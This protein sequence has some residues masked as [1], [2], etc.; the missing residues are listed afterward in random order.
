MFAATSSSTF[1]APRSTDS[2][3]R[4][5][6]TPSNAS[7]STSFGR[8]DVTSAGCG[9]ASTFSNSAQSATVRASGPSWQYRSRLNGASTG[10]RPCGGLN[11]TTPLIDA[12]IRIDPP[13][14]EPLAS[15]E[16]PLASDAPD[17]PL[18]PPTA[19]AGFHGLRVTP[20]SFECVYPA[21]DSSGVAVRA[22]TTAPAARIRSA[23]GAVVVETSSIAREP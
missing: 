15:V 20:H 23:T 19:N 3:T 11:P 10:T 18:D 4:S 5:P 17:P 7:G 14:S 16:V 1:H 13:M 6:S 12:G 21:H 2:A 8:S 22:C 9:P